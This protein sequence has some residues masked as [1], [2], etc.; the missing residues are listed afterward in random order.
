[1]CEKLALVRSGR[2]HPRG[3]LSKDDHSCC[4]GALRAQGLC[5]LSSQASKDRGVGGHDVLPLKVPRRLIKGGYRGSE[6]QQTPEILCSIWELSFHAGTL[7]LNSNKANKQGGGGMLFA[8]TQC[9]SRPIK[10]LQ[11]KV[12]CQHLPGT[13]AQS[14]QCGM[15]SALRVWAGN[16]AP[17]N[18]VAQTE[19]PI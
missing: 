9:T 15:H 8:P 12:D 5:T 13:N 2:Q 10:G 6:R 11:N 18:T 16:W 17:V 19:P 7:C 3:F 1:M 4:I 14:G